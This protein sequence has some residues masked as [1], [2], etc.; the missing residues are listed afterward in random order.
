MIILSTRPGDNPPTLGTFSCPLQEPARSRR[1]RSS[2]PS[3]AISW[4]LDLSDSS[5]CCHLPQPPLLPPPSP[6]PKASINNGS[7][8]LVTHSFRQISDQQHYLLQCYS[9]EVLVPHCQASTWL[10]LTNGKPGLWLGAEQ[11]MGG[12]EVDNTALAELRPQD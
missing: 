4:L 3:T 10:Q 5:G 8:H 12:W 9:A 6:P 7:L 1:R 11:P 2:R